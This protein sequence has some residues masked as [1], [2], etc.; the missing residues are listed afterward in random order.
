MTDAPDTTDAP[1][2]PP[3]PGVEIVLGPHGVTAVRRATELAGRNPDSR[4]DLSRTASEAAQLYAWILAR[5]AEGWTP[6]IADTNGDV[7][8]LEM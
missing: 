4:D 7:H 8:K 6:A 5:K 3:R 2:E 1:A